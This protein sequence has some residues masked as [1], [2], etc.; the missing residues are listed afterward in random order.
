MIALYMDLTVGTGKQECHDAATSDGI[1][2]EKIGTKS[3]YVIAQNLFL[4]EWRLFNVTRARKGF[5]GCPLGVNCEGA[6]RMSASPSKA[7]MLTTG[8]GV[9]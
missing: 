9:R 3:V 4:R 5:G 1:R 6:S 7:D 2:A 8:I